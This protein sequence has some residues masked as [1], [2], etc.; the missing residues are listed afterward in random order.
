MKVPAIKIYQSATKDKTH[1]IF[2]T[3]DETL[4]R[5]IEE[6]VNNQTPVGCVYEYSDAT[7]TK[8]ISNVS[9]TV[10]LDPI[11]YAGFT[12]FT[13][14]F[15]FN[16]PNS[17]Y[18][19]ELKNNVTATDVV[20]YTIHLGINVISS[21]E[22]DINGT[23]TNITDGVYI[24]DNFKIVNNALL[25]NST[26]CNYQL[27]NFYGFV[28]TYV[29]K[30]DGT[31]TR[32]DVVATRAHGVYTPK[33]TKV[34]ATDY[35]SFYQEASARKNRYFYN[36]ISKT[37]SGNV[38]EISNTQV[39]DIAEDPNNLDFILEASDDY[40]QST[41]PTWT[42]IGRNTPIEEIRILKEDLVSKIIP[43]SNFS[44]YAD[45]DRLRLENL[46]ELRITNIWNSSNRKLMNRDKKAFR[47]INKF[48]SV[49][50][51][52]EYSEIISFEEQQEVLIDKIII[53]KKNV[54][55]L[56]LAEMKAP[57]AMTDTDAGVIKVFIRQG[58]IYYK[59]FFLNQYSTNKNDD[60]FEYD[61]DYNKIEIPSYLV[62]AVTLD[63]R[64]PLLKIKDG[65]I[66]GNKYNYTIYMFDEYGKMSD[67]ITV[68]L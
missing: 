10:D 34:D 53:F 29:F 60:Y 47:A 63:S 16:I 20:T 15:E 67:P 50:I 65:C 33:L 19:I 3:Q 14:P 4:E 57:I 8:T 28:E 68:V 21:I 1:Y 24:N 12:A 23:V 59:D 30:D 43:T 56:S 45:D 26:L 2:R 52:S 66:Y 36:V 27:A 17:T 22:E 51:D 7:S 38:S 9:M 11:G 46:R 13:L 41:T 58:G 62:T 5:S 61:E 37:Y 39:I 55:G 42:E 6:Y 49:G 64:F 44:I 54:S 32:P 35:I 48:P 25:I 40:L 31:Q 18:K